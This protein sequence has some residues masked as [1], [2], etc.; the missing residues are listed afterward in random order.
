MNFTEALTSGYTPVQLLGLMTL[1]MLL[2]LLLI[3]LA[4]RVVHTMSSVRRYDEAY[5][6]VKR[7]ETQL[8]EITRT[9]AKECFDL[10]QMIFERNNEIL[11]L[12]NKLLQANR[13][14]VV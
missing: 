13:N 7:I 11:D 4:V 10:E 1:A 14:G 5:E 6:Q 9:H 3:A 2:A 12:K 8:E